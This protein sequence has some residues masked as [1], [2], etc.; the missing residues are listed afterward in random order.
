ME[1]DQLAAELSSKLKAITDMVLDLYVKQIAILNLSNQFPVQLFEALEKANQT[2]YSHP[3]VRV[4]SVE[5]DANALATAARV[6]QDLGV[7][8]PKP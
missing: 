8:K 5:T 1:N 2:V 7:P 4:L 6:L 3:S